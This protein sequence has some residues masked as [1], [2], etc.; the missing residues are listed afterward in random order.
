MMVTADSFSDIV[1]VDFLTDT[2]TKTI[3]TTCK[4][5]FARHGTPQVVVTDNGPQF[6]NETWTKF[7]D[8]WSFK[9]VTSSPYHAQGN[10]KA[11]SA[12]KSM[13]QLFKKC[14]KSGKDFWQALQQHRNT[15]NAIGTSPNQRIFSR[16]TRSKIPVITNK[17]QPPRASLV[18]DRIEQKRKVVKASYDRRAKVL[19]ELQ[20]GEDVM[21]QRRPDLD[22]QWERATLV[23]KFPDQSCEARVED[24]GLYRRS[25]VHVK[26]GSKQPISQTGDPRGEPTAPKIQP[27]TQTNPVEKHSANTKQTVFERRDYNKQGDNINDAPGC[28]E[29][30]GEA[31]T[32][33][34]ARTAQSSSVQEGSKLHEGRP[35][36]EIKKPARFSDYVV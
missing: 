3:V 30:G 21:V 15:P 14:V 26:P 20:V 6:S 17:L 16:S 4:R 24:G 19:P 5:N 32:V 31:A 10:G 9:H 7:A 35:K 11:E 36:R 34:T 13:K 2:K 27:P 22:K 25:A 8:D 1:E 28:D 23:H 12:V 18:E 33:T 29:H